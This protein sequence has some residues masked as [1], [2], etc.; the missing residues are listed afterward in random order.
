MN[1]RMDEVGKAVRQ[2]FPL[3][4]HGGPGRRFPSGWLMVLQ[5]CGGAIAVTLDHE[6]SGGY[7]TFAVPDDADPAEVVARVA[8][9]YSARRAAA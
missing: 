2:V 8:E 4:V 6:K 7:I 9:Q 3:A 5:R 1:P